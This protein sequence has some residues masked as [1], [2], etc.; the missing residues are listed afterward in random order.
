MNVFLY[1][2]KEKSQMIVHIREKSSKQNFRSV[3][4]K[5]ILL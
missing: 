2:I 3:K 5:V 1:K 4:Q